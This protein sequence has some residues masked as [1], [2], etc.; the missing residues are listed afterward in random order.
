MGTIPALVLTMAAS[1]PIMPSVTTFPSTKIKTALMENVINA[2]RSFICSTW[3]DLF[4][5]V[6]QIMW[7]MAFL[8]KY[9]CNLESRDDMVCGHLTMT[10][11]TNSSL[12]GYRLNK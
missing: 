11:E 4:V 5:S 3:W 8:H 9:L 10:W 7:E 6:K 2:N 12:L 1:P